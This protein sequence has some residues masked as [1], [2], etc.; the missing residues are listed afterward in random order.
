MCLK[1]D[2]RVLGCVSIKN[3]CS[4]D[5]F[6]PNQNYEIAL[7]QFE[8][9]CRS[10]IKKVISGQ[11]KGIVSKDILLLKSF[12]VLQ[13][14]RTQH[15]VKVFKEGMEQVR[16]YMNSLGMTDDLKAQ[17]DTY[18][19]TDSN[20]VELLTYGFKSAL[21]VT[22]DLK[23]KILVYE[24]VGSFITSDDPV[25]QYN[26]LL[27]Q[28][29]IFNY[30]L[31]A[32]GLLLLLPISPTSAIAL[33]D[34]SYYR[35]GNRKDLV[36]RFSCPK[37]LYW[38]NLL[39]VLHADKA[40]YYLPN[41]FTSHELRSLIKQAKG[42]GQNEEMKMTSYVADDGKSELIHSYCNNFGIGATF[43]FLKTLDKARGVRFSNTIGVADYT[44]PYCLEWSIR[45][46][47]GYSTPPM[48]YSITKKK[49][50]DGVE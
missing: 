15:E 30:G 36:V 47:K 48:S 33:Y 46:N 31:S 37:D 42:I 18:E 14:T 41:S 16:Q 13:K 21:E 17:F 43:S 29:K 24:G 8:G 1:E 50:S 11:H 44:R 25:I 10:A 32:I 35:I 20:V 49:D 26:P 9:E 4:K 22:V 7:G 40:I 45:N 27:E 34:E 3:Q 2:G 19:N 12:L 39:T 23:C 6:Y 28:H 38:I 5:Y